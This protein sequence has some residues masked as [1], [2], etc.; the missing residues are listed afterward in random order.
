MPTEQ[1]P[2]IANESPE[3]AKHANAATHNSGKN[4]QFKLHCLNRDLFALSMLKYRN[5]KG[6]LST[7]QHS[8]THWIK[9]MLSHALAHEYKVAPPKFF[10]NGSEASNVLIG[11][12]KHPQVHAHVPR[13]VSTHSIPPYPMQ[14]SWLRNSTHFPP[15]AVVV[16]DIRKVLI[17]NFE[18]W[19]ERYNVSFSEYVA[20]DPSS[21]KYICD[22]WWYVR[23][24]NRWGEVASRFPKETFVT[25]Y[26]DFQNDRAGSLEK[27]FLHFGVTLSRESLAA[28]AAAG[29]KSFMAAHQDPN[30]PDR[31]LRK[32]GTD[33]TKF[34]PAD[35]ALL[36]QILSDNLKHDFGYPYFP[37]PRGYQGR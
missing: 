6:Y 22:V 8:G 7:G 15:Y 18:K 24:M 25:K 37:A 33:E 23:Y 26:E 12:P 36:D 16:R 31:A 10:D 1:N 35:L 13:I 27:I 21:N 2:A 28:G 30:I 34:S 20:G 5:F 32:D 3:D 19:K 17:S 11:H 14:W 29:E 4:L 9:W